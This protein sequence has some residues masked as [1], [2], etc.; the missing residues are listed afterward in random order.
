MSLTLAKL[1][2]NRTSTMVAL[3]WITLH[4]PMGFAKSNYDYAERLLQYKMQFCVADQL[5]A[6]PLVD[7]NQV[8]A[9]DL[10]IDGADEVDPGFQLI[11]ALLLSA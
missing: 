10:A 1:A 8:E 5:L 7:L 9:I 3:Q 11:K 4:T 6:I 2:Q